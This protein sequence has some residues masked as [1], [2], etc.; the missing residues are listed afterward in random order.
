MPKELAYTNKGKCNTLS[1][2]CLEGF[3]TALTNKN[4]QEMNTTK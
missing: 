4:Q 2:C 3:P 1:T